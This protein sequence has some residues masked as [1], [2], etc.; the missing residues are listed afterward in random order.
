M[1]KCVSW[2]G[3]LSWHAVWIASIRNTGCVVV[4]VI[5]N[6]SLYSRLSGMPGGRSGVLA[7]CQALYLYLW[8]CGGVGMHT[9][10]HHWLWLPW[11]RSD[12][13]WTQQMCSRGILF[14]KEW[15]F[16]QEGNGSMGL[17]GFS[18]I[19]HISKTYAWYSGSM[20]SFV[21]ELLHQFFD[22]SPQNAEDILGI[23]QRVP[24]RGWLW[25]LCC[26]HAFDEI[27]KRIM[28]VLG[29]SRW[30]ST[31]LFDLLSGYV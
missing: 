18:P 4:A 9:C 12:W 31:D 15:Q 5:A 2:H 28:F 17:L 24:L 26:Q 25:H 22:W 7:L 20:Q 14:Q 13:H 30:K 8:Q 19:C 1:S 6:N 29:L 10:M 21:C 27:M 3:L 23:T 11:R 16:Q